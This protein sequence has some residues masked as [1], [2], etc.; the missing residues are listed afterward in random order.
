MC[1]KILPILLFL[2]FLP[3]FSQPISLYRQ[4]LGSYD[5]TMIGNTLL[6]DWTQNNPCT[7]FTQSSATLNL[8]A[9]Q[10]VAAAYLYWSSIGGPQDRDLDIALN[11][12]PI[13]AQRIL[14]DGGRFAG[15]ADVTNLVKNTGNGTYLFS[16][17]DAL[18]PNCH[19]PNVPFTGNYAG[20]AIV[21]VYE[22]NSLSGRM[23]NIYDGLEYLNSGI[24]NPIS[25]NL[26]RLNMTDT[27]DAKLGFVVW[28]GY[29]GSNSDELKINGN[30]I[31][32]PPLNPANNIYNS[33]NSYTGSN[34]QYKV[35]LDYFDISGYIS[36]NDTSI[37]IETRIYD[38]GGGTTAYHSVVPNVFALT[39]INQQPDATIVIDNVKV[40]CDSR[41]VS[42]SYKVFNTNAS[43][44]LPANTPVAFYADGT[45]VGT[46][47][48]KNTI[49]IKG[50]ET[51][52]VTLS[53]PATVDNDFVLTANVDDD[54]SGNSSVNEINEDNNTDTENATLKF[55][56]E[57]NQPEDI[58][59]CDEQ[60]KGFI[61]FDLTAKYSEISTAND[62][63][64]TFHESSEDAEK[65]VNRINAVGNYELES[66]SSKVIWV[67]AENKDNKCAAITFFTITAQMKPFHSLQEPLM[68]CNLKNNP[69]TVNLAHSHFLLSK[70]YP[71]L[72]EID[73]KFYET[74][75]NAESETNEITNVNNYQ[76]F[77]FPHIVWVKVKGKTNLWCEK[78]FQLQ[79]NDCVVP[80]GISPNGDGLND[81][82][83]IAIF[84]PVD[85]K[86]FNRYGTEVYEHGLGYTNQWHGQDKNN[87]QLP[88]GTYFYSFKTLFDTYI[89]YV[90]IMREVN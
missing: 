77:V 41:D 45:L 59:I 8:N 36:V 4:F 37:N 49:A 2:C 54:G 67:R 46:T 44:V 47:A 70:M 56:P 34:T 64:I 38:L 24:T 60:G 79:L 3:G 10:T 20:W 87:K 9:N 84:N 80:K 15:F 76:P 74:E 29:P 82:F 51:G 1:K 63:S 26:D 23:V 19:I 27:T 11:G 6:S 62:V 78:I 22:D 81:S 75:S 33:T 16:D 68:L 5:F 88:S 7:I 61:I 25:I 40:T 31:A 83:D 72:D 55:S 42:V 89:G 12:T 48:T 30:V 32:N 73:F 18:V 90:Y 50:S 17:F 66:H 69:S 53:I 14:T 57:I 85:I 71:Y 39:L 35:D 21:I 13:S 86:I 28:N 43:G 58:V 52:M 65:G